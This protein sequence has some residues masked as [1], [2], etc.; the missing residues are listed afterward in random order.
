MRSVVFREQ[1][2]YYKKNNGRR[3]FGEIW[4]NKKMEYGMNDIL[5]RYI[6]IFCEK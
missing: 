4:N 5:N 1:R 6:F 2:Y 3:D